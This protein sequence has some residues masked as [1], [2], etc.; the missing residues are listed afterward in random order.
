MK[1][2]VLLVLFCVVGALC[3]QGEAARPNIV[4]IMA[5]D[6]GVE[7]LG[8]Y[9]GASYET[10]N[11]DAMAASGVRFTHCYSQPL[12]T[13][14]R[15]QIMTGKYNFRNYKAF[16][17]LDPG[18]TTFAHLL[19]DAGYRTCVVG[20]WQLWGRH[21]QWVGTGSTPEQA[22]F[23][24][25]CL[26]QIE[27]KTK[28]YADPGLVVEGAPIKTFEGAYGPEIFM[29]YAQDFIRE[30]KDGPFFLYFPM[31]LPHNPFTPTPDSEVWAEGNRH[32]DHPRY[33]KDMVAYVDKIVGTLAE[34]LEEAGIA[35]NTLLLF[36]TDNGTNKKILS[37][38]EDGSRVKGNKG[39]TPN[40]G[41]HVPL[42][43]HWPGTAAQGV[44]SEDLVDFT[45]FVPTLLEV[46]GVATTPELGLDGQSFLPQV[47]GRATEAREWIYCYYK[48]DWGK[49]EKSVFA[50]DQQY[51]LY[52]DGRFFD[53]AADP[54]EEAPIT[55][56]D[57]KAAYKKLKAVLEQYP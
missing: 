45:D 57:A 43:A 37:K 11:L 20:K 29:N 17:H 56:G 1:R 9:G 38:M 24:Q 52:D 32:T 6:L 25:H 23:D 42:I 4:L 46:A 8:C 39:E 26:W 44:V 35:E 18:E 33:M 53:V 2:S 27:E 50:R 22:G 40:G 30:H 5:D 7:G 12:C 49:F 16:G 28:R 47:Q 3:A 41:T 36:T 48:P 55:K 15:V 31:A 10:P 21:D 34:T 19:K 54:M 14:S 51:K 13:P